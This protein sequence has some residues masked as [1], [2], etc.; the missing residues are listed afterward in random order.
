MRR[1][2]LILICLSIS[3][4]AF[5]LDSSEFAATS[6]TEPRVFLD[7]GTC[8]FNYIRTHVRFVNYV[9]DRNEAQVEVL[10]TTMP[11]GG[12]GREYTLFFLGREKFTGMND[13]LEYASGPS[14]TSEE[15]MEGVSRML[16]LGLIRY[17]ERMPIANYLSVDL[18]KSCARS[19]PIDKWDHWV[20][21]IS[22]NGYVNGQALTTRDSWSGSVSVSRTT[23]QSKFLFTGNGVYQENH[24][25]TDGQA[26]VAITRQ[27]TLEGMG[28]FSLGSHWSVGGVVSSYSS[29]YSNE[30]EQI[31]LSPEVEYD[32]FPYSEATMRQLRFRYELGYQYSSYYLETIFYKYY[33]RLAREDLSLILNLTQ[34]WGT[35]SASLNGANY[36]R[37]FAENDFE[38]YTQISLPVAH[39]LSVNL[40]GDVS[41]I[42]DQISLPQT[43]AT[44]DQI[45]LQQTELATQYSYWTSFGLSFTFGSIYNN[46]VNPRLW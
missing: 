36:L 42:H 16:E 31:V 43:G 5:A 46:V 22:A 9:R 32:F 13:T 11:T 12:D 28:A 24:Y 40:S 20:F 3:T 21:N 41:L 4:G 37:D 26:V 6:L 8:N 2:L 19:N 30:K 25:T 45:L 14:E 17:A 7:C 18:S 15:I 1:I 39:G 35:I 27:K 34:P 29:T 38:L 33:D 44:A 23:H 10:I